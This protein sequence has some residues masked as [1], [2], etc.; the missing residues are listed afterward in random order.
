[1]NRFEIVTIKSEYVLNQT[2]HGLK[3]LDLPRRFESALYFSNGR[4]Q[5]LETR[6]PEI[7]V[8]RNPRKTYK[9]NACSGTGGEC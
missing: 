9:R 3:P 8:S 1:M 4:L 7:T 6:S 5:A 2:V